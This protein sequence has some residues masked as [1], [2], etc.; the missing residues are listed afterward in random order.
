[1][2]KPVREMSCKICEKMLHTRFKAESSSDSLVFANST[3]Q[4]LSAFF[5]PK[6]ISTAELIWTRLV[7][8]LIFGQ[9]DI[10]IP[11]ASYKPMEYR[12][13]GQPGDLR[14]LA[15]A[16]F[17]AFSDAE[18][19]LLEKVSVG[20]WAI[21]GTYKDDDPRNDPKDAANWETTRQIRAKLVGWLCTDPEARKLV[22]WRGIQVCGA[23]ITGPLD[24]CF[25]SI[26]FRLAFQRCHLKEKIDLRCAEVSQLD[27]HGSLVHGIAADSIVV[28]NDVLMNRGFATVGEVRLPGAQVGG[29]LDCSKGTFTN[30][31]HKEHME[32]LVT[33][34]L[35]IIDDLGMRKLPLTAAEELLEIIMRR[36]ERASTMLTSNRPVE[37]W[38]KLLGDA[39]AVS[40]MLDRLLHHG[41]VLKCGPR[42]WRTKTDLPPQEA[43]G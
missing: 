41:H 4:R 22:H 21:C 43:A 20:D 37:D 39:A 32:F 26:P 10:K 31:P 42:S 5:F 7:L 40:A 33:V 24:L 34:P 19:L 3:Y 11:S 25:V 30:P 1:M 16:K 2:S 14:S 23:D 38:G 12:S 28:K 18:E 35:L 9:R 13:Q 36:Y 8:Y 29:D 6:A 15:Q 17:G 27:F